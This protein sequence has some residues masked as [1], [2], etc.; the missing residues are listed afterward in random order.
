[1]ERETK[2][3]RRLVTARDIPRADTS[4]VT[5]TLVDSRVPDE[6]RHRPEGHLTEPF[7]LLTRDTQPDKRRELLTNRFGPAADRWIKSQENSS[8]AR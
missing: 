4:T 1:M 2:A 7:R 5:F 8:G 6:S 3:V